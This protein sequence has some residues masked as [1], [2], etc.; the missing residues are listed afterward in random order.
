[1][2]ALGAPVRVDFPDD[3]EMAS[4][5]TELRMIEASL[6]NEFGVPLESVDVVI[7]DEGGI[8][9]IRH[10]TIFLT[11]RDVRRITGLNRGG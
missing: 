2:M 10:A 4:I 8:L 11:E 7:K 1:M 3:T 5:E 6:A 9:R